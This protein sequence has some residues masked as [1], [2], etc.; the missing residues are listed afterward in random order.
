MNTK[1][2]LTIF[3]FCFVQLCINAQT[4]TGLLSDNY[5]GVF[6]VLRNP[7]SSQESPIK[8]DINFFG[9]G[10]NIGNDYYGISLFEALGGAY[11]FNDEATITA[12]SSNNAYAQI[13]IL[14][15]SVLFSLNDKS[16]LA[17][18][19]RGR[20]FTGVF[21]ISGTDLKTLIDGFDQTQN[22]SI[23]E[24]NLSLKQN[25][26]AE[27]G[28][29]Y[30][31]ILYKGKKHIVTGGASIKYL[32]GLGSAYAY[33][34]DFSIDYSTTNEEIT[35]TGALEYGYSDNLENDFEDFE[36]LGDAWGVGLDLGVEYEWHPKT[37]KDNFYP[38][39]GAK[40]D[41]DFNYLLKVGLSITDFGTVKYQNTSKIYNLNQTV[42]KSDFE[43]IENA[44]DLEAI[45]GISDTSN[46]SDAALPTMF[47]LTV[48]WNITK[49][50]YLN[51]NTD[52][53][54][55]ASQKA[56]TTSIA[57]TIALTPRIEQK[58]L[59]VQLPIS[60]HEYT[61][62]NYGLGLRAGP[63]YVGSN[64][65][66]GALFNDELKGVDIYLGI[67]IPVFKNQNNTTSE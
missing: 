12:T 29:S 2:K 60:Y 62:M 42:T 28:I 5:K 64:S 23:S 63:L 19:T 26:W 13:D 25:I 44:E 51:L 18:F 61:G 27:L 36:V 4:Y 14:G 56:N 40:K 9:I 58:W 17:L 35:S 46:A 8:L 30:S 1:Y 41:E 22:F 6:S 47:H 34:D 65:I 55:V 67:K 16:K 66:I 37:K 33:S 7:A 52:Y 54:V 39:P 45:Y 57:N 48:D 10:A 38:F 59:G 43:N 15:P 11:N 24:Q 32:Q 21:G 49:N 3:L 53:S 50:I 31:R 20:S